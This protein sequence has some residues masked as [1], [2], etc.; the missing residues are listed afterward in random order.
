MIRLGGKYFK[1]FSEFWVPMKLDTVIKMCLN[2]TYSKV[3]SSKDLSD[4]FPI[5]NS[6]KTRSCFIAIAFQL[7]FRICH[8]E[9]PG[10]PGGT[11]IKWNTSAAGLC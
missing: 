6:L 5:Q 11:E 8:L 1:I 4:V 2:E 10:K 9:G 3:S 7:C